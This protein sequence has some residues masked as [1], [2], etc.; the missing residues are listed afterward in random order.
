M[1]TST[2]LYPSFIIRL[3]LIIGFFTVSGPLF[4]QS[5]KTEV[6]IHAIY[7]LTPGEQP[8]KAFTESLSSL[9]FEIINSEYFQH[10]VLNTSMEF[11]QHY[12]KGPVN[13]QDI[14]N[15]LLN[16]QEDRM[17]DF[18]RSAGV[19][20]LDAFERKDKVIDIALEFI[21]EEEMDARKWSK[22]TAGFTPLGCPYIRLAKKHFDRYIKN[23]DSVSAVKTIVHEYM[24]TLY[25]NHET[26]VL[27]RKDVP[28]ATEGIAKETA[29]WLRFI[30]EQPDAIGRWIWVYSVKD[31]QL[32]EAKASGDSYEIELTKIGQL[33]FLRNGKVIEE[34]IAKANY[35]S[36]KKGEYGF[37]NYLEATEQHG[38][39]LVFDGN[40]L[41][42]DY[43][44]ETFGVYNFFEKVE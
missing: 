18:C 31:G 20:E 44:P 6:Q 13:N 43:F 23:K 9:L 7:G 22:I 19:E 17:E 4:G 40:K 2:G 1:D 12:R 16:A 36:F 41:R 37:W 32:I 24:H 30:E 10:A 14:L 3:I 15:D 28:Y 21:S 35:F 11:K 33:K 34:E 5:E 26:T 29:R 38:I 25:Y 8:M 42:T 39:E 27:N